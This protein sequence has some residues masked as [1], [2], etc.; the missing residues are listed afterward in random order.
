MTPSSMEAHAWPSSP[1]LGLFAVSRGA[2]RVEAEPH[3]AR[4]GRQHELLAVLAADLEVVAPGLLRDLGLEIP[5]RG[6]LEP[7]AGAS[8]RRGGVRVDPD[9]G[10]VHG[11]D[12]PH[13][14]RV[15]VVARPQLGQPLLPDLGFGRVERVGDL[16][17][18]PAHVEDRRRVDGPDDVAGCL[19]AVAGAALAA[20][21]HRAGVVGL[22]LRRVEPADPSE[23]LDLVA[24]VDVGA[25]GDVPVVERD[26]EHETVVVRA[27]GVVARIVR[28]P[29]LAQNALRSVVDTALRD[30]VVRERRAVVAVRVGRERIV[31]RAQA[32]V[33][34]E[35][36]GEVP[37]P[38]G[39]PRQ[40]EVDGARGT[41]VLCFV[42]EV[43][44]D[45]VL[46]DRVAGTDAPHVPLHNTLLRS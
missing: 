44:E 16:G 6:L 34:V 2:V 23:H 33:A 24:H 9:L 4:A 13:V 35:T 20:L 31:D 25:V 15:P 19:H 41:Y 1:V 11:G 18:R 32:A 7:E 39:G 3:A 8:E 5:R 37:V 45:L 14:R 43:V 10:E 17:V 12:V 38:L 40:R 36:V 27:G 30:L 22:A 21:R 29:G 28:L 46:D 42:G 26:R